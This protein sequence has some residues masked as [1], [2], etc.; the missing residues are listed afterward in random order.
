FNLSS[1]GVAWTFV[2]AVVAVFGLLLTLAYFRNVIDAPLKVV[3]FALLLIGYVGTL[4][5]TAQGNIIGDYAGLFR[6]SFVGALLMVPPLV[7]RVILAQYGLGLAKA[8][9]AQ[10]ATLAAARSESVEGGAS[11][12]ERESV[13][14][15]RALGM[16]LEKAT[17]E[18]IPE[19]IVVSSLTVLRADIGALVRVQ[20]ANYADILWGQDKVLGRTISGLSIN[21][22]DQPTLVNAIER[23]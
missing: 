3:F 19:R 2:A 7:F 17:L 5:Q 4:A 16:M 6:L 23:R 9:A 1:Y 22:D 10:Q 20:S 13:Q 8:D 14:L 12:A 18:S 21:L 15:I 11:A